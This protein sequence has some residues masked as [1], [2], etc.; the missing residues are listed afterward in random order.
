MVL[1]KISSVIIYTVAAIFAVNVPVKKSNTFVAVTI[2]NN[3]LNIGSVSKHFHSYPNM[4]I[5]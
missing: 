3:P 1:N 5:C 4:S 2:Y